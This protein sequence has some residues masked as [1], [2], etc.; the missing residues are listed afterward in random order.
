M[1]LKSLDEG[2]GI[3]SPS[4]KYELSAYQIRVSISLKMLM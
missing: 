1:L 2:W 4:P 3:A